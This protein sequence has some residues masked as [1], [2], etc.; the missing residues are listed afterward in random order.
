MSA[1]ATCLFLFNVYI[2]F[3]AVSLHYPESPE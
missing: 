3:I 2:P 1:K